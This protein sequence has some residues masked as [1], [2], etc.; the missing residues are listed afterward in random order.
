MAM[1]FHPPDDL[2]N[3]AAAL[4]HSAMQRIASPHV[5]RSCLENRRE[6]RERDEL[7]RFARRF[8]IPYIDLGMD[9][10][11]VQ[12]RFTLAAQAIDAYSEDQRANC[13]NRH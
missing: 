12:R 4:C 5:S 9:V 7:E 11:E 8:L 10:H 3:V 1:T 13:V 2:G 6:Y